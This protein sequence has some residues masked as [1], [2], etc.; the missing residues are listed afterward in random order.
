M[1]ENA[2]YTKSDLKR[3][4]RQRCLRVSG[5]KAELTTRLTEYDSDQ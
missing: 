1:Y 4:L 5:I 2:I 3:M